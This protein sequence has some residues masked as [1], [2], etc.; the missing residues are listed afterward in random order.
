MIST[1][2]TV[3][4]APDKAKGVDHCNIVGPIAETASGCRATPASAFTKAERTLYT[5]AVISSG[6]FKVEASAPSA[7]S[8]YTWA[9]AITYTGR[10]KVTTV[11]SGKSS[12]SW[13]Q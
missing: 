11:A 4:D 10:T 12:E 8:C 9:C 3:P 13:F 6:T 5:K 2:V 7:T 1:T